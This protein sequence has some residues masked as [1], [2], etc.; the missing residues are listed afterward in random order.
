MNRMMK[1]L[2]QQ[3]FTLIELMIVVAI[4]GILAAVAVPA[5][6]DYMNKGKQSEAQ[7]QLNVLLKKTKSTFGEN[8]TYPMVVNAAGAAT[9]IAATITPASDCCAQN[10]EGKKKCAVALAGWS[11]PDWQALGFVIQEPHYFQY[12]YTGGSLDVDVGITG[13][14]DSGDGKL[15]TAVATGN[16]DCDNAPLIYKLGGAS[17][18][19]QSITKLKQTTQD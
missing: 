19:G 4:I 14:N 11:T 16:L 15:F 8:A 1:N 7:L 9:E 12:T 17:Q 18:S 3:G 10:F 5:F 13:T 6:M 2:K